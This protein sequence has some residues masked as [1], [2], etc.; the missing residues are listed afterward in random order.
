METTNE[1]TIPVSS[2][3]TFAVN[4]CRIHAYQTETNLEPCPFC[5][6]VVV[7]TPT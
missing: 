6:I 5:G 1:T 3:C 4:V 2:P 7:H